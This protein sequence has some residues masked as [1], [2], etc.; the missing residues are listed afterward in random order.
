M[1]MDRIRGR[2]ILE[3]VD[4]G[5]ANFLAPNTETLA[6][7]KTLTITDKRVQF[8]DPDGS[9]RNVDLPAE[10]SSAGLMFIICNTAGGAENLVIRND[11]ASTVATISQNEMGMAICDGTTWKAG[12]MPQS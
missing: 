6:G 10:A 1:V 12:M 5:Q 4:I 2:Q 9:H 11:A 8:L 3:R 7:T